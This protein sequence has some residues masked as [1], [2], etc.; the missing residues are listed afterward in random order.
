MKDWEQ[1]GLA[2][3]PDG[4]CGLW[5]AMYKGPGP[6]LCHSGHGDLGGS[7]LE[8][9]K[10]AAGLGMEE[11]AERNQGLFFSGIVLKGVITHTERFTHAGRQEKLSY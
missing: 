3:R 4:A 9:P 8:P 10:L 11:G 5:E 6:G 2:H 7:G 1:L